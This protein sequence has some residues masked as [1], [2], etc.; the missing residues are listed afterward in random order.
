[1]YLICIISVRHKPGTWYALN[2]CVINCKIDM[3]LNLLNISKYPLWR[4]HHFHVKNHIFSKVIFK[5]EWV[6]LHLLILKIIYKHT[7][8]IFLI[9][10]QQLI[11]LACNTEPILMNLLIEV[12][13]W[14]ENEKG[15]TSFRQRV[16]LLLTQ[17]EDI[18]T[19]FLTLVSELKSFKY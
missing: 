5:S 10:R 3:Y 12:L 19:A 17:H 9:H 16:E 13:L 1:M 7:Q 15:I 18:L 2:K 11:S 4:V 8:T 6:Q 14:A